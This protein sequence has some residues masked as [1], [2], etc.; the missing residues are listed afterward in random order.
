MPTRIFHPLHFLLARSSHSHLA[1]QIEFLKA[2]NKILHSRL[3]QQIRTTRPERKILLNFGK[4]LGTAVKDLISIVTYSTF[5]CWKRKGESSTHKPRSVGRPRTSVDVRKLIL[6]MAEENEWGAGRIHGE[7][8]KLG[9]GKIC[10][11]TIRNILKSEGMLPAPNRGPGSWDA[12]L[13]RHAE[14]IWASDFFSKKIMTRSGFLDCFVLFVI[15][16]A[17][18]RVHVVGVTTNPDAA[19]LAQQSRNLCMFFDDQPTKPK[20]LLHDSD[21]KYTPQFRAIL[22]DEGI[23]AKRLPIFSPNM[24]AY[25]ERWVRSVR[26]ECVNHFVV[27]GENHMQHLVY[28]YVDW[29]NTV[30]PHQGLGNQPLRGLPPLRQLQPLHTNNI[31]IKS[32]LGGLLKHYYYDS[33]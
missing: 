32:R 14:T 15:H 20:Y 12:F 29:Y 6:Q 3:K 10:L 8:K 31:Q 18:R 21:G 24:N 28:E 30:R 4:P 9:I 13:K 25:A 7:L 27:F 22:E 1:R 23:K 5:L 17:T 26:H 16:I 33:A 2:E 11:R 19:W